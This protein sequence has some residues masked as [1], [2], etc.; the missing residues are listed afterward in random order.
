MKDLVMLISTVK[1]WGVLFILIIIYLLFF[2]SGAKAQTFPFIQRKTWDGP[3]DIKMI[4]AP[5]LQAVYLN[6]SQAASGNLKADSLI[7]YST[8]IM[9][10][11]NILEINNCYKGGSPFV[12]VN[13][14]LPAIDCPDPNAAC[15]QGLNQ[16][17][18]SSSCPV[19]YD[20]PLTISKYVSMTY[21][22][23]DAD[24]STFSSSMAQLDISSCSEIEAAYL[25][26]TG[27]FQTN[28][29]HS[30]PNITLV[31][32]PPLN[33][34]TGSGTNVFNVTTTS[35]YQTIKFKRPGGAY[36]NVT[37]ATMTS[38]D[39]RNSD[40][41]YLCVADVTTLVQG[42][43]GGQFWAANIQSYP[44]EDAIGG[45]GSSSG[46]V[47]VVVFRSPLSPPRL[48]SLWDG[49]TSISQNNSQT[50]TL[51]GLQ[52]PAV[53]NFQSYVGFAALDG[54]NLAVQLADQS[55]PDNIPEGLGFQT[56][57]GGAAVS[58]NPFKTDQPHYKLWN[59]KGV[60]AKSDGSANTSSCKAPLFDAN[61]ASVYDGVSSSHITT[62]DAVTNKNGNEIVRLPSNP[63]TLGLDA[64]HMK[65]PDGAVAPN[66]TQ[67]TLTVNAGPQ[68]GTT[69]FMAYIAI[70]RLQPKLIMTKT[71]DKNSTGTGTTITYTLRIKNVGNTASLGNDKI[72]DTLDLA[73]NYGGSLT[74]INYVN[75]GAT[76]PAPGV[77]LISSAGNN[78]EFNLLNPIQRNDSVDISFRVNVI[79]YASNPTL[80]D[81]PQCK[82]TITNIAYVRYGTAT[83]GTLQSKSNSNDCGIGSETRVL[84]T[85]LTTPAT[86]VLGP[87]NACTYSTDAVIP[88]VQT[89]LLNAGVS[90]S[91]LG[92][93]DIRTS[94]DV[95]VETADIFASTPTMSYFAYRD[96]PNGS[97]CQQI[98]E[99]KY[100]S[101]S[102]PVT[103]L[104][105]TA[106]KQDNINT[107]HWTTATEKN[108]D[109]YVIERSTNGIDFVSI[110]TVQ[111]HGNSLTARTYYFDDGEPVNGTN[112]YRLK[113]LDYNGTFSYSHI[114]TVINNNAD[115]GIFPNPNHGSFTINIMSVNEPYLID[116]TDVLGRTV[117][118]FAGKAASI[119]VNGLAKSA[120]LVRFYI[121]DK[122]IVKKLL[123]F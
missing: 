79:A 6:P 107:L 19:K 23:Y 59:K 9:A 103:W 45:G 29:G 10:G 52:A 88:H 15:M 68:G 63:N 87:F 54:E 90:S 82:R 61:W 121:N 55:S 49:L 120:Y 116:I 114:I 46:W 18:S 69:P 117:Y 112:Y 91:V 25:Y 105:F 73:T 86:T 43:G 53:S 16:V 30:N 80:F 89:E 42:T 108:N 50:F 101:C 26:W 39:T 81:P 93:F 27:A 98:Y 83:S 92:Q 113:Q 58:I 51:T 77:T 78:M 109:Y 40:S 24:A 75:G 62:Y 70:E 5:N 3:Y 99:I 22:D 119:D 60:P 1:K 106:W 34:Y 56:N 35:G 38:P 2:A 12:Q 115:I 14:P 32:N 118:S 21:A 96:F 64:H 66:A 76:S 47:L 110:G 97:S 44:N 36:Q 74:S 94:N 84:L 122:T 102:L 72:Y 95:R 111:A 7:K 4:A 13:I 67:A 37:A 104:T 31:A 100:T 28:S 65:L 57:A 123:V 48:I 11:K 33:S 17:S 41:R 85:G 20:D 8:M 71:A